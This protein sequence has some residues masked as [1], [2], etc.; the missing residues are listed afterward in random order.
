M[1]AF[2]ENENN[3]VVRIH[4]EFCETENKAKIEKICGIVAASYHN[5]NGENSPWRNTQSI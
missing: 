2:E 1:I 5:R 3:S 4:D